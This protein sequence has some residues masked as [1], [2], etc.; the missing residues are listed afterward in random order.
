MSKLFLFLL[1]AGAVWYGAQW[2]RRDFQE[3]RMHAMNP[4]N[5]DAAI[6]PGGNPL[7]EAVSGQGEMAAQRPQNPADQG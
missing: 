1:A 2:I 5:G 3:R 6:G 4:A 7:S